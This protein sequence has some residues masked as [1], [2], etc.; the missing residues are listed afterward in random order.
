M[1]SSTFI[2]IL[3]GCLIV[4]LFLLGC[5]KDI[6]LSVEGANQKEV[7]RAEKVLD[8]AVAKQDYRLYGL[9]GRRIVLPGFESKDFK[10]IKQQCGVKLMS[11]T[12]DTLKNNKDRENRRANYK[13]A[14]EVNKTLYALCLENIAK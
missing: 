14:L 11:G 8:D 6:S 7:S 9:T 13:F 2:I 5:S 3:H 4:S 1:K 10:Q 12:G